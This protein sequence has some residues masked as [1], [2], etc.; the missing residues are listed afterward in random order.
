MGI[1]QEGKLLDA[2]LKIV[3]DQ[4]LQTGKSAESIVTEQ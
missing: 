1:V 4:M 3:M 2:Q